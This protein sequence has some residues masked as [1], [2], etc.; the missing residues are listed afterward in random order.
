MITHLNYKLAY[1]ITSNRTELDLFMKKGQMHEFIFFTH[2]NFFY[3]YPIWGKKW[4]NNKSSEFHKVETACKMCGH[5]PDRNYAGYGTLFLQ[6]SYLDRRDFV[7]FCHS[8][9]N[10]QNTKQFNTTE[11]KKSQYQLF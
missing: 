8:C 3:S 2:T 4:K 1:E 11:N 10:W 9:K 7:L 5:L 6:K